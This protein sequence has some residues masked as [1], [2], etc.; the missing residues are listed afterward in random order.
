MHGPNGSESLQMH[1]GRANMVIKSL[2][3]ALQGLG[4]LAGGG[5]AAPA[6]RAAADT[7]LPASPP[8]H[9]WRRACRPQLHTL[10]V[11]GQPYL[12]ESAILVK[13]GRC[14]SESTGSSESCVFGRNRD[15]QQRSTFIRCNHRLSRVDRQHICLLHI[16]PGLPVAQCTTWCWQRRPL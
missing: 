11:C 6:V 13:A 9:P 14:S 1:T 16:P 4:Y 5:A 8:I 10:D 2:H 12:L 15:Q 7:T 3:A